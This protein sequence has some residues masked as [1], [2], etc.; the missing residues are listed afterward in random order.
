MS[1]SAYIVE[2]PRPVGPS[3]YIV[4]PHGWRRTAD[5]S[6]YVRDTSP[7]SEWG[8]V[9]LAYRFASHRAAAHC[10]FPGTVIHEW[11]GA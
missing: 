7:G 11:R 6:G 2:W 10:A 3:D 9:H 4:A 8:P 5:G 1:P